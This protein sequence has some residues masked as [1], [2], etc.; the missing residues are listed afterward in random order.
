M[1]VAAQLEQAYCNLALKVRKG[2]IGSVTDLRKDSLA[3]NI[4]ADAPA[5]GTD[6][7][8]T[9]F[10]HPSLEWRG[11]CSPR[12]SITESGN[13]LMVNSYPGEVNLEH[14]RP[15]YPNRNNGKRFLESEAK[16]HLNWVGNLAPLW[17]ARTQPSNA[18]ICNQAEG[19]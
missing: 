2:E 16:Y 15:K 17:P 1:L 4:P 19:I 7:R 11:T 13:E 5:S 12:S 14:V 10:Q 8:A 9:K 18:G 3:K 6:S